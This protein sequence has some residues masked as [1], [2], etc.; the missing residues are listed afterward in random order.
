M[1]RGI[2]QRLRRAGLVML[3]AFGIAA[4]LVATALGFF[5]TNGTIG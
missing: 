1:G 5:Y 2:P 3:G 4:I